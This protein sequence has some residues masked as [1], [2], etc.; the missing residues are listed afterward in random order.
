[1]FDKHLKISCHGSQ[2]LSHFSVPGLRQSLD[3]C[4][5]FKL[6]ALKVIQSEMSL[7]SENKFFQ[8]L[9]V[10]ERFSWHRVSQWEIIAKILYRKNVSN[11]ISMEINALS[12]QWNGKQPQESSWIGAKNDSRNENLDFLASPAACSV[13]DKWNAIMNSQ[14]QLEWNF[15]C[16]SGNYYTPIG[17]N[18]IDNANFHLE[19]L[20]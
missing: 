7:R 2:C 19:T 1:M 11:P 18:N 13:V 16:A 4:V 9:S 8:Q 3:N 15:L 12:S 6:S 20:P 5:K 17:K 10:V 14:Q